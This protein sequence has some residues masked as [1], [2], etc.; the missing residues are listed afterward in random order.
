MNEQK[1][2]IRYIVRI[3]GKDLNGSL[4][5]GRA[6]T[7]IK[8]IGQRMA[9]NIAIAFEKTTGLEH[10]ARLGALNEEQEKKLEEIVLS[11]K[12]FGVPAWSLNRKKEYETGQDLH[13]V[14][15][16][17]DFA[18]RQNLQRLNEIKSYRGLR[19]V[20]GLPVRGQRTRS[21]HRGKGGVVGVM[22]KEAKQA[23]SP[24]KASAPAAEKKGSD[25][26]AKK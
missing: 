3:A 16:E 12:K 7:G 21:T 19:L 22:K 9:Q 10:G 17:L 14:T 23:A 5:I 25:K 6:L 15:N 20:W 1:E 13:F 24:A 2:S 11:P 26:G 18:L 4:P 8:G